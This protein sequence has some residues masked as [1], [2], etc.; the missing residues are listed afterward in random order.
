MRMALASIR[1]APAARLWQFQKA[2]IGG[3]AGTQQGWCQRR[4]HTAG[5]RGNLKERKCKGQ[6]SKYT[7]ANFSTTLSAASVRGSAICVSSMIATKDGERK[8]RWGISER[9]QSR[10]ISESKLKKH[11]DG[12]L[13]VCA[14]SNLIVHRMNE[15]MHRHQKPASPKHGWLTNGIP[16]VN[17]FYVPRGINKLIT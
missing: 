8:Q 11:H 3:K 13:C 9:K 10:G 5:V 14:R 4:I 6:S 15:R 12:V 16:T 2:G 7:Y 1:T 17:D